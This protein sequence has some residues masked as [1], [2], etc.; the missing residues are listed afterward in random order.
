M[1]NEREQQMQQI[2]LTI[3]EAE[4]QVEL[5]EALQRLHKN[6]DFKKIILDGYFEKTAQRAVMAKS[7]VNTQTVE[8]QKGWDNVIIGVGQLGQYFHKIFVFGEN[9][10]N[11]LDADKNTREELLAE[12]LQEAAGV[13]Q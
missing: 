2:E 6:K 5:A 9:A 13:L 12:D 7:D 4:E 8:A 3:S 10:A 11:A 1:M